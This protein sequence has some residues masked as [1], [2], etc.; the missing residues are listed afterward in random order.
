MTNDT[1]ARALEERRRMVVVKEWKW[2]PHRLW[3]SP[4]VGNWNQIVWLIMVN[5]VLRC[6]WLWSMHP[7]QLFDFNWYYTHA[8][9]IYQGQGYKIGASYTAYWPMGYPYFLS[10]MFHIAGPSVL[11]GL[12]ANILLSC[13]IV[14]LVYCLTHRVTQQP[15]LAI[16][17]AVAY[18]LLPSQIEWNSVLGSE[19]LFTFLLLSSLYTYLLAEGR[20]WISWTFISGLI[21]GIACTVRPIPLLFP[22]F[23]FVFERWVQRRSWK[24]AAIHTG[25][26]W[27]ACLIAICPLTIRN[28]LALHHFV[29][30]STNGGVNLWQGTKSSGGYFW[31]WN[32]TVNPLLAAGSNEVL[33]NQIG[34]HAFLQFVQYH[35]WMFL[36]D[37]VKKIFFLYWVDWNVVSVTFQAVTPPLSRG[38]ISAMMWFNTVVY[39]GWMVFAVWGIR[40]WFRRSA[41]HSRPA[42]FLLLYILY[43]TGLFFVFPAWDRFRYPLMPLFAVFFAIGWKA[44]TGRRRKDRFKFRIK[45]E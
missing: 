41:K 20:S 13:G 24:R 25:L 29:L 6:V 7:A 34:I 3:T 38:V 39:W 14:V 35:P 26:L 45:S 9:Q 37:G 5:V 33:E 21:L 22:L 28:Y 36:V 11:A 15:Q 43:N 1:M 2:H 30:V 16:I 23:V 31:S 12:L 42:S 4:G 8:A 44:W 19:A 40:E 17:A 10:L 27:L 32:P 18:S